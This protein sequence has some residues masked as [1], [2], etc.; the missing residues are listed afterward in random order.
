MN[1]TFIRGFFAGAGFVCLIL[2]GVMALLGLLVDAWFYLGAV[3]FG[4]FAFAGWV[5]SV[6]TRYEHHD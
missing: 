5:E 2:A 1:S 4:L 3:S 6:Q